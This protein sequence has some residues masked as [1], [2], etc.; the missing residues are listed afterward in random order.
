MVESDSR[1]TSVRS[2][3]AASQAAAGAPESA[4]EEDEALHLNSFKTRK[5]AASFTSVATF[6][7]SYGRPSTGLGVTGVPLFTIW[8]PVDT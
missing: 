5:T 6:P 3:A 1:P 4:E 7:F 8:D 2:S